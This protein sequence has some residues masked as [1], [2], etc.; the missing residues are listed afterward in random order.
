MRFAVPSLK[1]I[2]YGDPK[3]GSNPV[4][5]RKAQ[6]PWSAIGLLAGIGGAMGRR[7]KGGKFD[8]DATVVV[9]RSVARRFLVAAGY[10]VGVVGPVCGVQG[11][12]P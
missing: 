2:S 9:L 12:G 8:A 11:V 4:A 6:S 7:F 5:P 1:P 3:C 10:A